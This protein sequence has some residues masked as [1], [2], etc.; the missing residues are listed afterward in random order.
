MR[1]EITSK[2]YLHSFSLRK[3]KNMESFKLNSTQT[4]FK[5]AWNLGTIQNKMVKQ[6]GY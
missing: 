5:L 2:K 6:Q 4:P 1:K 3:M